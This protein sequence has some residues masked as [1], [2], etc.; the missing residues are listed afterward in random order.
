MTE[1]RWNDQPDE[2]E[3]ADVLCTFFH[4]DAGNSIEIRKGLM[5]DHSP[6]YFTA[7]NLIGSQTVKTFD[8]DDI[9]KLL[10]RIDGVKTKK[11]PDGCTLM[12]NA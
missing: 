12:E 4:M 1:K 7:G 2:V 9:F 6:Y 5:M 3:K 10:N 11:V 8:V